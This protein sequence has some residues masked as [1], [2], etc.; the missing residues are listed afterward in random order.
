[1]EVHHKCKYIAKC[2]GIKCDRIQDYY[3]EVQNHTKRQTPVSSPRVQQTRFFRQMSSQNP[4][5][6]TV[7]EVD[8]TLET[9]PLVNTRESN[10]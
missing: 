9:E 7:D 6:T 2:I 8:E 4:T 10:L 1:M 3:N 5:T